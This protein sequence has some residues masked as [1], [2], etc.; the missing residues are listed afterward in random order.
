MVQYFIAGLLDIHE[1]E[2]LQTE[3]ESGS[4]RLTSEPPTKEKSRVPPDLLPKFLMSTSKTFT[5]RTHK[6]AN[7]MVE[8]ALET[9]KWL[10]K[11]H[12]KQILMCGYSD[13]LLINDLGIA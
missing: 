2:N 5:G 9:G 6:S 10:K 7:G 1:T 8:H 12:R 4:T 3:Q 11:C 13:I